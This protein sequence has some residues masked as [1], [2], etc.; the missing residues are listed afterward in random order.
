MENSK[1]LV[2]GRGQYFQTKRES[3]LKKYNVIGFLDNNPT[4]DYTEM[5]CEDLPVYKPQEIVDFSDDVLVGIAASRNAMFDMAKQMIDIGIERNRIVFLCELLPPFDYVEESIIRGGMALNIDPKGFV[6]IENGIMH[7]FKDKESYI[8]LV[9]TLIEK[10]DSF[11]DALKNMPLRPISRSF[12]REFG[13]P[14]DRYYIE[15]FLLENKKYVCG[16]VMEIADNLYTRKFGSNVTVSKVLH[17]NGWN[18]T[19]KGDLST[20]EGLVENDLDCLICTQTLQMI[21]D[22][23]MA[24]KN[25]HKTLKKGGVALVTIHGISQISMGDYSKWG[26][27]WRVTRKAALT[28][29]RNAGFE[30]E[31]VECFSYGNVKTAMCFLYGMCMEQLVESDFKYQDEQ[32]PLVLGIKLKK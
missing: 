9:R 31:G 15:E 1:L 5:K 7:H 12:G 20:G 28:L 18:G 14:I 25:I 17:I 29:A 32:Y 26:E 8:Q 4:L 27:H 16:T 24:L 3:I 13:T 11:I 2:F 10:D 21:F 23:E 19:I 22:I 30:D 6:L